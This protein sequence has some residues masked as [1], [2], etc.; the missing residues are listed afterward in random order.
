MRQRKIQTLSS[1][2]VLDQGTEGTARKLSVE[3]TVAATVLALADFLAENGAYHAI[4]SFLKLKIQEALEQYIKGVDSP[5]S[6]ARKNFEQAKKE[7]PQVV[8]I[9]S[10]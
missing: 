2:N 1:V 10:A 9:K 7:S 4:S 3:I 5:L 8:Q 6:A